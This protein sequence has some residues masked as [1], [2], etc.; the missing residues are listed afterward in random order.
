LAID[1]I[2]YVK[3]SVGLVS[4]FEHTSLVQELGTF[5]LKSPYQPCLGIGY[6]LT[7]SYQPLPQYYGSFGMNYINFENAEIFSKLIFF[8][9]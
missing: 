2:L 7:H 1:S 4:T 8:K 9:E 3:T 6:F 5:Y